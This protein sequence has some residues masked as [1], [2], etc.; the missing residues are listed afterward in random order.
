MLGIDHYFFGED[1]GNIEKKNEIDGKEK[2]KKMFGKKRKW[3]KTFGKTK[4]K[5]S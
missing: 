3:K 4:Q 1:M 2:R 5:M